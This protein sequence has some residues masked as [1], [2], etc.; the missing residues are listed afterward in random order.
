MKINDTEG[1]DFK[2]PGGLGNI[3]LKGTFLNS[4]Q[5]PLNPAQQQAVIQN[6]TK[7]IK[8]NTAVDVH[9]IDTLGWSKEVVTGLKE[10]LKDSKVKIIFL[11]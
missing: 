4:K 3:S 8:N 10:A 11:E 6:L 1:V 7:P 2:D 5:Q 9:I